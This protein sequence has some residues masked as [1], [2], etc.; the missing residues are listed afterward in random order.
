MQKEQEL[1]EEIEIAL[2]QKI[3]LLYEKHNLSK[4]KK[5][6]LEKIFLFI[7]FIGEVYPCLFPRLNDRIGRFVKKWKYT[8]KLFDN[9]TDDEEKKENE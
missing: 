4:K 3:R 5:E 7:Y 9:H 1:R 8:F 2:P 6:E